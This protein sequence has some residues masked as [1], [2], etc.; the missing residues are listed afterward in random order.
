MNIRVTQHEGRLHVAVVS[1]EGE[2]TTDPAGQLE[3]AVRAEY[4][5]GTRYFVLDLTS[6]TLLA[7]AGFRVLYK[8]YVLL[9]RPEKGAGEAKAAHLTLL[10]P[11]PDVLRMIRTAGFHSYFQIHVDL[12]SAL[13]SLGA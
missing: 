5:K 9:E 3:Q 2:I 11:P 7:S 4:D 6:A 12:P 13:A 1:V 10:N 8:L